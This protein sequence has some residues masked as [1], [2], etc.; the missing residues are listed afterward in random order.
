MLNIIFSLDRGYS[1]VRTASCPG[2]TTHDAVT[3]PTDWTYVDFRTRGCPRTTLRRSSMCRPY[4]HLAHI[5]AWDNLLTRSD[6]A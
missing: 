5:E 3:K 1:I 6:H 2:A 4:E